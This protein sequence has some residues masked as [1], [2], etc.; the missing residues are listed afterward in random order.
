M[1]N[2]TLELRRRV[3]I[4]D[5][6]SYEI[7]RTTVAL[8]LI[9]VLKVIE[10]H[11]L[12]GH[13]STAVG[14]AIRS[15]LMAQGLDYAWEAYERLNELRKPLFVRVREPSPSAVVDGPSPLGRARGAPSTVRASPGSRAVHLGRLRALSEGRRSQDASTSDESQE[16]PDEVA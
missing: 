16:P 11:S 15:F 14:T 12:A 6:E 2:P 13:E 10:D 5:N 3:A 7:G 9:S 8:E 4:Q 1:A